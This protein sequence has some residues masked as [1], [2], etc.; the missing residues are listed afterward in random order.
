MGKARLFRRALLS[1]GLTATLLVG[2]AFAAPSALAYGGGA[3]HDT[4]QVGLSFNCNSPTS[5]F[6]FDENGEPSTG[7]FWGWLE[8]DR[9]GTS[10]WGD[11]DLAGCGHTV[12]GGGPGT[13]GAGHFALDITAWHLGDAQPDDPDYPGGKTFYLDAY[14]VTFTGHGQAQTFT[15]DQV[16]DFLGDLGVPSEPGHYSFHPAPGVAGSVQV[17]YRAAK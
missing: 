11:A 15:S 2:L 9:S 10:T 5:P 4:W 1:G 13:A 14:T 8:F 3:T 12:G 16:P 7:G 17:A 6:C